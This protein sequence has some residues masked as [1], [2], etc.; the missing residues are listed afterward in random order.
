MINAP[1]GFDIDHPILLSTPDIPHWTLCVVRAE[2]ARSH[3]VAR[4]LS[5][6]ICF[7]LCLFGY[8]A[9]T[10]HWIIISPDNKILGS[11]YF[12]RQ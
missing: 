4:G 10:G 1:Y 8:L 2:S 7:Y 9:I 11:P 5:V 3:Y 6:S 12:C